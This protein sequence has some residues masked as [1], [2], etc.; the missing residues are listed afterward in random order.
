MKDPA[1]NPPVDFP[2]GTA[3]PSEVCGKCHESI[4]FEHAF[5][6]GADLK[7]NPIIY[8]SLDEPL[9]VL[10]STFSDTATAHHVAGVDPW[11]IRAREV[12]NGGASCNVCHYPEAFDIPDIKTTTVIP[13]PIPRTFGQEAVGM[14]CASCHLTPDGRIRGSYD[15]VAP[16]QNVV[17][18]NLRTSAMC[19]FCHSFG[20]RVVGKQTQTF[21]EWRDDYFG[22]GLG[23]K[24]CH[25]CHM[26]KTVRSLAEG[27]D[28]PPRPV[29][30]HLWPGS[31]SP[32]IIRTGLSLS[33]RQADNSLAGPGMPLVFHVKNTVAG[34]SV[35][36]GSNRRGVY[37]T[38]GVIDWAGLTV[39]SNE[40][41]FA[42]WF[43]NRPD[44]RAL[45]DQ[46]RMLPFPSPQ[47][48]QTQADLQGPHE[49]PVRA[50]EERILT[51]SPVLR[52]G[53][54]TVRA[55]LVYDLNRYN[56]RAFTEDQT[57]ITRSSISIQ[58]P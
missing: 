44:D 23:Y 18:P 26:P 20:P 54:Y 4:Y 33:I 28:V 12:D 37:L 16:H 9:L 32:N 29:G 15:V 31:H 22:A 27:Y 36:T 14:T 10:P 3:T 8:K 42:P 25:D 55:I 56:D 53:S 24:L 43:G 30:A 46:D 45:L 50:G 41:L 11:P 34:H 48:A 38:V 40:W 5:G 6:L 51:W 47:V 13:D 2:L 35:P 7:W 39:A 52:S 17:D 1:A 49:T 57:E 58:V 21:Y 19:A